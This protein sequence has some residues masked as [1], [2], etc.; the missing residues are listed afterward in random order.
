LEKIA[1]E[2]TIE[3]QKVDEISQKTYLLVVKVVNFQKNKPTKNA[4]VKVFRLEKE[5]LTLKQWAENL[6]NGSPFKRL[7]VSMNTD[8]NGT[9]TV[10]LAEGSYEVEEEKFGFN[11]VFDLTQND[12]ILFIEP[13][14]H[15]WH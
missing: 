15:W 9:V 13:R 1:N 3:T 4:T 14:K 7:I 12:E 11:K 8:N 6:K 2:T 10:E 5:P